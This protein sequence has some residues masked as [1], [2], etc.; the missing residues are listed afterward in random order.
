MM[1]PSH[2]LLA[3]HSAIERAAGKSMFVEGGCD[4]GITYYNRP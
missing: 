2:D 4:G 1:R 3:H